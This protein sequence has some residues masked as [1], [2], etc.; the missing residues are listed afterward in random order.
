VHFSNNQS[1]QLPSLF[2]RLGEAIARIPAEHRQ[3]TQE[4]FEALLPWVQERE[5]LLEHI[6]ATTSRLEL[7][8]A[9]LTL[10]LTASEMQCEELRRSL[11]TEHPPE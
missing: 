7:G 11:R 10:E 4:A 1:R 6:N 3:Q 9:G 5:R 8:L 2:Q